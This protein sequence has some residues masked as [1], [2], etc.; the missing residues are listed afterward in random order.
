MQVAQ[1]LI[2]VANINL[3]IVNSSFLSNSI[4][5]CIDIYD[6]DTRPHIVSVRV[7]GAIFVD[8]SNV[9]IIKCTF[10]NNSAEVGGA[11]Y[12]TNYEFSNNISI[13]NSTFIDN[14]ANI[15]SRRFILI[16]DQPDNPNKGSVAGAIAVFQSKLK[17]SGCIFI[18]N[19]SE[20]G[21]GGALAVQQESTLSSYIQK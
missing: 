18:N 1:S 5:R 19:T 21:E 4:G 16:C 2:T 15:D 13:S 14:Q 7:G 8:K 12:S 3:M 6:I 10:S 20:M 9:S 17:I 11:I